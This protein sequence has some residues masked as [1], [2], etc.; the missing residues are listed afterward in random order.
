MDITFSSVLPKVN[1]NDQQLK[2]DHMNKNLKKMCKVAPGCNYS[3]HDGSFRLVN[4]TT[5]D[6]MFVSDGY[7]FSW[8][9]SQKLD[10]LDLKNI[11]PVRNP[12]RMT[13]HKSWYPQEEMSRSPHTILIIQLIVSMVLTM[14]LV[15]WN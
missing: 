14:H 10:N 13:S 8:K 15:F 4:L 2:I 7:H 3:D 12:P 6:A 5:N 11:A 1:P 9:G